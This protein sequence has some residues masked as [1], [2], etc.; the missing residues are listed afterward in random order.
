MF[1][2]YGSLGAAPWI[3]EA[4]QRLANFTSH[5]LLYINEGI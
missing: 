1:G 5:V 2:D 3:V 4:T